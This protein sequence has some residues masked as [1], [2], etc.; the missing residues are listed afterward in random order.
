M[1]PWLRRS[2]L[3]G[4]IAVVVLAAT[5]ALVMQQPQFGG[6]LS[7]ERLT[8]AQANPH[9]HDGVFANPLPPAGYTFADTR[10]LLQGQLFGKEVREPPAPIPVV[11]VDPLALS[12][13]PS[14]N[15]LRTFWIGHATVYV[16]IDGI[17]LLVDPIFS[18]YASPFN[19][20]PKRLHPTPITIDELPPIDAVLITHDHYDHLDMASVQQLARKGAMLFVPLGIGAH[21]EVWGIPKAQIHEFEW[22]QSQPLR[23]VSIVSTPSRHY[24]GRRLADQ[25][26]T[27]WTSWSVIGPHH[28]VYFSGDT[29]YS[30]HFRTI[31]DRLGPFD[32][33]FIKIGAYGPTQPW[34]DIHMSAEDAVRASLDV[35]ARR[36]FPVHWGTFNLAFHDWDEPIKRASAAAKKSKV[37]LLTPK[38]GDVIDADKPFASEAW[39]EKVR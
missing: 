14:A 5:T 38:V 33:A 3:G 30:D 32:L 35:R 28:R 22:W 25:N 23:G 27:L 9:F 31:G 21:L 13:P 26:A 8:R 6:R 15:G 4:A 29:G 20:G 10:E 1:R 11:K 2:L 37:D 12:A 19:I 18:E 39:W 24:S 34:I 36:M 16:E 7:G 17:R